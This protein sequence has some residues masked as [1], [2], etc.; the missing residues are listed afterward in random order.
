VILV[1]TSVWIRFL[2]GSE[3]CAG[4]LD[5]LLSRDEVLGHDLVHGE[6]LIGDLGSRARL[7]DAY[8]LMSRA[9]TVD[10]PEVVEFV[11]HRKLGR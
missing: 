7:L 6:L 3:P 2:A 10:H 9:A 11:R 8:A 4:E 5:R 1:D